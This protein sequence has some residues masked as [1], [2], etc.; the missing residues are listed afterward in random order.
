M[1]TGSVCGHPPMAIRM[2][3]KW[4]AINRTQKWPT[5]NSLPFHGPVSTLTISILCSRSTAL[6]S[7][8]TSPLSLRI[9]PS[10][11]THGRCG[12]SL[13]PGAIS[14]SMAL[15]RCGTARVSPCSRRS[16]GFQPAFTTS[17]VRWSTERVRTPAT[18]LQQH[19]GRQRKR[20]SHRAVPH[21]LSMPNETR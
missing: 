12:Q 14:A 19:L 21:L 20:L 5:S 13:E 6:N 8:W 10:R 3:R 1:A 11:V 18:F 7:P 16:Q 15:P 2:V 9:P 4:L 17:S